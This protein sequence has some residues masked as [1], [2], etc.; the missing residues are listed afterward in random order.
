MSTMVWYANEI[1]MAM[2]SL[3]DHTV[4]GYSIF[5]ADGRPRHQLLL[6]DR[7]QYFVELKLQMLAEVLKHVVVYDA[8]S[9]SPNTS[10]GRAAPHTSAVRSAM[11]STE[12]AKLLEDD[13]VL[14]QRRRRAGSGRHARLHR[15][16]V[17]GASEGGGR[18]AGCGT[19][20]AE[21]EARARGLAREKSVE[22]ECVKPR[23]FS[24]PH[25]VSPSLFVGGRASIVTGL[26]CVSSS[27]TRGAEA[28]CA[29]THTHA[30]AP[31]TQKAARWR[32]SPPR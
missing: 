4:L 3:K 30:A 21:A 28:R 20:G 25:H 14:A 18:G 11:T 17:A 12:P 24:S 10:T 27:G 8:D 26:S 9:A 1:G 15:Q 23:G 16:R 19:R 29:L 13:R 32:T 7:G 22:H 31:L 2:R 5:R 6:L